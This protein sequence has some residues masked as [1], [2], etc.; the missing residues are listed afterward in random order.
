MSGIVGLGGVFF[1]SENPELLRKWYHEKL[2]IPSESWGTTF[3]FQKNE[4]GYQ[5]WSPFRKDTTYFAPST[6]SFMI[7]FRVSNLE[8]FLSELREKN[9]EI[10]GT[11][12]KSEFGFFAWIL[13]PEGNKIEL[14]EPPQNA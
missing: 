12:E 6:S 3:A 10:V 8:Q 7:N 9:V 5:V 11:P 1:K 2:G 13:D 4:P 14:W